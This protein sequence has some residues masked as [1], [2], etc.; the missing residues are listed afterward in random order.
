MH[1]DK[2][3]F[4]LKSIAKLKIKTLHII[5]ML[6]HKFQLMFGNICNIYIFRKNISLGPII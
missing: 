3:H 2:V 5:T 4:R 6:K 1:L